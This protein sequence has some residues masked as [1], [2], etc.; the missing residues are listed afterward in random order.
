MSSA[1]IFGEVLV[2][3]LDA[4]SNKSTFYW[5]A[6]KDIE[7]IADKVSELGL[8]GQ[9]IPDYLVSAGVIRRVTIN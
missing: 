1:P 2:E 9:D 3:F 7:L 6:S 4:S 8:I 5:T